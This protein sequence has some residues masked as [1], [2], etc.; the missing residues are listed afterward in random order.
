M[1]KMAAL[2]LAMI[3]IFTSS[4]FAAGK[5]KVI[6]KNLI[7]FDGDDTG[8]FFAKVQNVGDA[9][10]GVRTGKLV[11]FSENDEIIIS[12]SIVYSTPSYIRLEPGEYVYVTEYLWE[13]IL[14][15]EDVVDYKFSMETYANPQRYEIIPCEVRY[16]L[17]GQ[18]N[19]YV[20]VTFT[21]TADKEQEGIHVSVALTDEEDHL[22]FVDGNAING[23]VVHP[24]S[25]ITVKMSIDSR[26]IEYYNNHET[27]I[28]NA[29]AI[30]RYSVK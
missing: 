15:T 14:E 12:E 6:S 22:V 11:G 21:N 26:I 1:K 16:E 8:Y 28:V 25:T 30:V 4:A 5:L 10:I 13:P 2:V 19:S 9:A 23:V 20:S 29:D 3:C 27:K 17:D 7:E 24:G 18:Y